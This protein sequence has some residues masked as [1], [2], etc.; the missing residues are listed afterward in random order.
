MLLSTAIP[1]VIAAI[2]I[3][4]ISKGR[5]IKPINP[6]TNIAANRLGIMPIKDS[7][8]ER[9]RTMNIIPIPSITKPRDKIWE[10]KRLCSILLYKTRI[11]VI[12]KLPSEKPR[13][14]I[15]S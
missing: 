8:K 7:F 12:T 13:V 5:L 4:I 10:L 1:M 3:V 11:P 9:K 6:K 14:F 15:R 2:V